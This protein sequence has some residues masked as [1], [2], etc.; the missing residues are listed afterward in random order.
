MMI[1]LLMYFPNII[2]FYESYVNSSPNQRLINWK[3]VVHHVLFPNRFNP[4]EQQH[5]CSVNVEQIRD[6][7]EKLKTIFNERLKFILF[8]SL[9]LA[10]YSSFVPLSFVQ[11]EL[12]YDVTWTAQHVVITWLSSF[13]MLTS[14][15]YSPEFYDNLHRSALHLGKWI[16][17]EQRNTLVPCNSWSETIL[18]GQGVVVK[19]S[20]EYFKSEGCTNCAEPGN[21]LHLRYFVSN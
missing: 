2:Q 21:Q 18:Y 3:S 15:L 1:Y 6:E 8:R 10:Y 11:T 13:L 9:L 7:V 4:L 14:H 5:V 16:K 17:L 12:F 20:K 19:H